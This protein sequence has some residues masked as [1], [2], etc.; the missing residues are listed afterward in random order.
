[1]KAHDIIVIYRT[2]DNQGPAYYRSVATSLCVVEEVKTID[3]FDNEEGFIKY[4]SRYS[5][6]TEPELR[7]FY[8][9]R[10]YPYV[11]SFTYNLALPKR[12]NRAKLI[13]DVGLDPNNYW[14]V[15]K[16]TDDQFDRITELG[17][18]N[19]SIIVN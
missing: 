16:L 4:C 14:G 8:K 12:L 10:K 17:E 5:I 7:G 11:I 9:S 15:L 6:F 1:M 13:Q 19:E 2:S 3:S 18:I